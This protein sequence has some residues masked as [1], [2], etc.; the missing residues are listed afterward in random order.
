LSKN[1]EYA[2]QATHSALVPNWRPVENLRDRCR[3]IPSINTSYVCEYTGVNRIL[4]ENLQLLE[5]GIIDSNRSSRANRI[6][7]R[8]SA[9]CMQS[10]C[11]RYV[12]ACC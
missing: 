3:D 12:C 8:S 11:Q 1:V 10:R 4:L 9:I 7:F 2:L 6:E 5:L